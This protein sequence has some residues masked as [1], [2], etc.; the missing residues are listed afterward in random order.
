MAPTGYPC[1]ALY[2]NIHDDST[3]VLKIDDEMMR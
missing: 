1:E 2:M 3:Q